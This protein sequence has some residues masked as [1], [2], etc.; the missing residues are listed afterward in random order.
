MEMTRLKPLREE[1]E[2]AW[3]MVLA[4][5]PGAGVEA[6]DVKTNSLTKLQLLR[7]ARQSPSRHIVHFA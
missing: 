3:A 5:L 7:V 2:D 4:V 6:I 1:A